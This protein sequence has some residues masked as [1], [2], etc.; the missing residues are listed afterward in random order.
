MRTVDRTGLRVATDTSPGSRATRD[1]GA[2][3][4]PVRAPAESDF[5]EEPADDVD[6]ADDTEESDTE[7]SARPP[8]AWATPAP[9][10]STAPTPRPTAPDPSQEYG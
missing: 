10:D 1:P 6:T 7:G 8:S 5:D 2:A 9:T 4:T 3:A